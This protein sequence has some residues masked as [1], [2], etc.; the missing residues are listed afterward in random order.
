[1][2]GRVPVLLLSGS[3]GAGKT[4]VMGEISDLLIEA[5]VSHACVD[6]DGLSLIH[7][8]EPADPHGFALAFR[9]LKSIWANYC[10]AGIERLVI[11]A[12][13]ESRAEL[14]HYKEA[15]PGAE[16]VLCRLVAPIATM[17]DRIRSRDPGIYLPR[18]LARSTELDGV[19]TAGHIEDFTVDNGPG[20][21]V[22][23]VARDV[24]QRAG[25]F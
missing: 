11:A 7:P 17:H 16:I 13:I 23:D 25:W 24:L 5:D 6:F 10:A 2:T 4:T 22:T 21:H 19:L 9:N 18:F 1:M 14:A 15:V 3:M 12:V 8:H 20:R